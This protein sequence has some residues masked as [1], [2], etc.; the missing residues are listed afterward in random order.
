MHL[1]THHEL[2]NTRAA[3]LH[4]RAE[5]DQIARAAVQASRARRHGRHPA[6]GRPARALARGLSFLLGARSA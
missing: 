1:L 5:R 4:H 2:M 3:G 6:A